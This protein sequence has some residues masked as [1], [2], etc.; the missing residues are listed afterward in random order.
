VSLLLSIGGLIKP[1]LLAMLP[2]SALA[3][4]WRWR[5]ERAHAVIARVT[6][7]GLLPVALIVGG[8]SAYN[9]RT[10]G[11]WGP[12]TMTGYRLA[13]HVGSVMEDAPDRY[14]VLRDIFLAHR[15]QLV[16]ETGSPI[17]AIWAAI[18][19]MERATGLPYGRL[20]LEVNAMSL[21]VAR[22]HPMVLA[23]SIAT[24]WA[25]FWSRP[26]YLIPA[27][28]HPPSALAAL[29][30]VAW[31]E[32]PVGLALN[33][34]LLAIAL[35]CLV[36]PAIRRRLPLPALLAV[37]ATLTG[38]VV[39]AV[40][41]HSDNGRFAVP[42]LPLVVIAALVVLPTAFVRRSPG[43]VLYARPG[44]ISVAPKDAR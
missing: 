11:V 17:N 9:G 15:A 4:L 32:R 10:H 13:Q 39:Q 34:A 33:F 37:A 30:L 42:F 25:W 5:A 2:F 16:A 23:R 43:P 36:R 31:V 8:F 22:R 29:R 28:A 24:A 40:A 14:R 12:S 35:A 20:S 1:L 7:A 18:P 26:M 41:E 19:D 27:E 38:S 3:L 6:A 44:K 21:A